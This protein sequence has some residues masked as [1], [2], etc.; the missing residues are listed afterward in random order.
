PDTRT[1]K[2][3]VLVPEG[4]EASD[5]VRSVTLEGW[6]DAELKVP[7]ANRTALVGSRYPVFVAAEYDDGPVH[8]AVVAQGIVAV[9]GCR[10]LPGRHGRGLR[11]RGGALVR[12]RVG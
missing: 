9:V 3:S 2:V 1:A 10:T 6:K 7:V 5:A 8:Q 12:G 4:L 11:V